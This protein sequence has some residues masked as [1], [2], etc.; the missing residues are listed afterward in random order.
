LSFS[1]NSNINRVKEEIKEG[2]DTPRR[3]EARGPGGRGGREGREG[4]AEGVR[5]LLLSEFL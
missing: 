5:W 3:G 2:S 4:M 1:L